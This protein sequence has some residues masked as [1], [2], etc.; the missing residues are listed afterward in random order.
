VPSL[1]VTPTT[2]APGATV[3]VTGAGFTPKVKFALTTVDSAG[4]EV[5]ITSNT[6]RSRPDG[7][8]QVGINV[9]PR[10]GPAKVRAYQSGQLVAEA[11]ITVQTAV[12]P[13][14]PEGLVITPADDIRAL[15]AAGK[16]QLVLRSG[17]YRTS[18]GAAHR[19]G[20]GIVSLQ[21]YPGDPMPAIDGT[22][23]DPHFVYLGAG[24]DWRIG[25]IRFEGFAPSD[26]GIIGPGDGSRLTLKGTV[27]RFGTAA[28]TT[29]GEQNRHQVYFHGTDCIG[30]LED[31]DL[32]GAPG[33]ALQSYR[34][35]PVVTVNRGRYVA[36]Y[37]G[38]LIYSGQWTINDAVI[39]GTTY[40]AETTGGL[41]L[42][43]CTNASGSAVRVYY[44]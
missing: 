37:R 31:C 24:S 43:R 5:G 27:I 15:V 19:S 26:S 14:P 3:N 40:D 29:G 35:N 33:A 22:G 32:A 6:N 23:L 25:A 18:F 30:L 16:R 38:A 17:T 4:V 7:T 39:G 13:P 42:N 20:D 9:P 8:F 1:T 21:A 36:N 28:R 11:S 12:T 34:G 44:A 41:T 10:E 2:A